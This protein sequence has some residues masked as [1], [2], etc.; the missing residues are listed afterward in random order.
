MEMEIFFEMRMIEIF[1][2]D[3]RY[4]LDL[5][6]SFISRINNVIQELFLDGILY[7][8]QILQIVVQLAPLLPDK[9][10]LQTDVFEIFKYSNLSDMIFENDILEVPALPE[11]LMVKLIPGYVIQRQAGEIV[12]DKI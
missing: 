7:K 1:G 5:F 10:Q 8:I 3:Q 4:F 9:L 11:H 2:T 6:M 12:H